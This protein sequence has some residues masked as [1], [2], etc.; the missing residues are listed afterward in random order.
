MV[1]AVCVAGTLEN[2]GF[3]L[4]A[5]GSVNDIG[6]ASIWRSHS[7]SADPDK[8]KT[9]YNLP[10]YGQFS[11]F[12]SRVVVD[13]VSRDIYEW[14]ERVSTNLRQQLMSECDERRLSA[15][16]SSSLVLF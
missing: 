14:A 12:L 4:R 1:C 6:L 3:E 15:F 9:R 2:S 10:P 16:L 7:P 8:H 13:L 11:H 5:S